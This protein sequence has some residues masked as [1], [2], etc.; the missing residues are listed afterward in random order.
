[1]AQRPWPGGDT[2]VDKLARQSPQQLSGGQGLPGFSRRGFL[3]AS[4]LERSA[5]SSTSL[6]AACGTR[7][8]SRPP[9]PARARTCP[10]QREEAELLQ[11]AALHRRRGR[12][13][14]PHPR[15]LP[16]ADRHQGHLQH[17]HQ[18]QQRVLRQGAQPARRLRADRP[19]HHRAHR[20][21]GRPDG[22]ASAGSRSST[23][24]TCPNVDANLVDTLQS[25]AWDPD[26][27]VLRA[28]AERP[29]RH[30]LQ[31]KYTGEVSQRRGAA[32]PR[33]PQGQ[34]HA[35]HRDGRHDGLHAQADRAP[36][37]ATSPTTSGTRP[38]TSWRRSSTPARSAG[39]PA[40][41]TPGRSTTATSCACE[42][43]SGDVIA[44]QYDNPDIKFVAPEEG[45]ALWSDNMLV[46]EQGGPQGQRREADELLLRARGRGAAGGLGQL[47]LPGRG[48][49]GGDGE[50]R[51]SPGRQPADLPRPR[52]TSRRPS[53][54][55]RSTSQGRESSTTRTST[56]VI[57]CA[58]RR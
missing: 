23:R 51:P 17:G 54:S 38:S 58:D 43:W 13:D 6:L 10:R 34:D 2:P 46:P 32:H 28:V 18:R 20:L 37:R 4:A 8:P 3:R 47:H 5:L 27:E 53:P 39:S 57:G 49:R 14:V 56:E 55:W 36:T 25:P 24:P 21:D 52:T 1:M 22:R 11:L 16:D 7:A 30:R 35:A 29:D 44:V 26:R 12:Q 9:R 42:A 31:P 33:R 45:L 40:T 15:R 41:T 48:R 50:D 19:R